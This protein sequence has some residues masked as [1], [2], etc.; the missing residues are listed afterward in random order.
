[1]KV[2]SWLGRGFPEIIYQSNLLIKLEKAALKCIAEAE[3]DLFY[4]EAFAGKRRLD[5]IVEENILIEL[6][7]MEELDNGCRNK[8]I[9]YLKVFEI[10]VGLLLN[11]GT[12]CLQFKRFMNESVKS[13][14]II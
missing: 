14:K 6:K 8:I 11:F 3:K 7:A 4:E 10:E 5:I 12:L 2:H 13:F 1:M 9:S